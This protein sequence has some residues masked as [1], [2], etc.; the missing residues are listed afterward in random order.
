MYLPALL[1]LPST[2]PFYACL[3]KGVAST[4]LHLWLGAARIRTHDLPLQ[5]QVLY[6]LSYRGC[7]FM[8]TCTG[9]FHGRSNTLYAGVSPFRC[10]YIMP[11]LLNLVPFHSEQ[12]RFFIYLSWDNYTAIFMENIYYSAL[13]KLLDIEKKYF[14]FSLTSSHSLKTTRASHSAHNCRHQT[15]SELKNSSSSMVRLRDCSLPCVKTMM[16]DKN[17]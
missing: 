17:R 7:I 11:N 15:Y 5:K 13:T 3:S 1:Y 8:H 4:I 6:Q 12:V 2:T 9:M 14:T 16:H 10:G